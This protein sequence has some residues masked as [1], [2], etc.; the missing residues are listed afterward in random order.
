MYRGRVGVCGSNGWPTSSI[1]PFQW[2]SR[3]AGLRRSMIKGISFFIPSTFSR[4]VSNTF[5]CFTSFESLYSRL[6]TCAASFS[7]AVTSISLNLPYFHPC[8]FPSHSSHIPHTTCN[9]SNS[10][11]VVAVSLFGGASIAKIL[12]PAA[13]SFS[14]FRTAAH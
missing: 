6:P 11:S 8:I 1:S 13:I 5:H 7:I 4:S 3:I 12:R 2:R 14:F 10:F 9:S